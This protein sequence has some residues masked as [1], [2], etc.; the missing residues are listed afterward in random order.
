MAMTYDIP[1]FELET[2]I[3]EINALSRV[4][5]SGYLNDGLVTREFENILA[6]YLDTEFAICVSSGTT[7]LAVTMMALGIGSGDEVI[8]PDLTFIATANAVR[9]CGADVRLV[10]V[11]NDNFCIDLNAV[12]AAINSK[13]KAVIAV[14]LNGRSCDY[15]QL[16]GLCKSRGINLICDSAESLG[17]SAF[18]RKLGSFGDAGIFSFSPSKIVTS[19][20]GGAIVTDNVELAT[21][22]REL[23]D[24]GR[25]HQGSGGDDVHPV[26]GFNF[27]YTNLQ[28]AVAKEQFYQLKERIEIVSTRN[29]IYEELI[30]GIEGIEFISKNTGGGA[31]GLWAEVLIDKKREVVKALT[32]RKIQSRPFWFPLHTQRPYLCDARRFPNS[33]R[34]SERGLWLPSSFSLTRAQM[35]IVVDTLVAVLQTKSVRNSSP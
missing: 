28:A 4:M 10:D 35:A 31:V 15:L 34:I 25:R 21:R 7:A 19:G 8:V 27:K 16:E 29:K 24:Q 2:G 6:G 17:S 30:R 9:L 23:K 11:T 14:D 33:R 5:S 32:A 22:I 18:G 1:W 3:A 12:E 20:Q 26:V 13:T